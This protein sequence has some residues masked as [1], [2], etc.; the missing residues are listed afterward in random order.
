ML[1]ENAASGRGCC[2][3]PDFGAPAT[4]SDGSICVCELQEVFSMGQ[5][6]VS[7]HVRKLREAGLIVEERRGRWSFYALDRKA[8]R[9]LLT[10]LET[11]LRV[12]FDTPEVAG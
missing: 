8:V 3:L 6:K 4:E 10:G 12:P 1:T 5:S 2:D 7:Y 11:H 9:E